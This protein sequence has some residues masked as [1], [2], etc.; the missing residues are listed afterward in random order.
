MLKYFAVSLLAGFLFLTGCNKQDDLKE[1]NSESEALQYGKEES[2]KIVEYID[3]S[4][5]LNNEKIIFYLFRTKEG[6]GIGTG[7][8]VH[9][10]NKVSWV[11][12]D[13]DVVVKQSKGSTDIHYEIETPSG[14]KYEFYSGVTKNDNITIETQTNY[15]IKPNIYKNSDI[16]YYLTPK[17]SK[18]SE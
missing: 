3:E 14:T 13:N 11:K 9:K 18:N 7:T 1:F 4:K 16:Y 12:F 6:E 8:L 5:L 15:N 17:I 10:N 2:S